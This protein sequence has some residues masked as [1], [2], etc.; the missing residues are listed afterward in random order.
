MNLRKFNGRTIIVRPA[1]KNF[2]INFVQVPKLDSRSPSKSISPTKRKEDVS[3]D[4][5]NTCF[6]CG[7]KGHWKKDCKKR[8]KFIEDKIANGEL[9]QDYY[10]LNKRIPSGSRETSNSSKKEKKKS[11]RRRDGS[12]SLSYSIP[13]DCESCKRILKDRKR[14]SRKTKRDKSKSHSRLRR[15]KNSLSPK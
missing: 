2:F 14:K 10:G 8:Q 13:S 4:D 15:F 1:C 11:S 9:D 7:K 6:F 3:E 12:S 5:K